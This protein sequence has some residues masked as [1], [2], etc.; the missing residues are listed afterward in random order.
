M[1]SMETF[2]GLIREAKRSTDAGDALGA[3]L[4]AA[5]VING[6][7]NLSPAEGLEPRS[8]YGRETL[9]ERLRKMLKK[10]AEAVGEVAKTFGALEYQISVGFPA[11]VS[12]SITFR[13]AKDV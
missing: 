1:Q 3:L 6:T 5:S 11:G 4:E 12:C 8:I 13:A 7:M 9:P 10:F 2:D